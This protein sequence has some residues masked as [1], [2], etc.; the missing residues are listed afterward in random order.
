MFYRD[1]RHNKN[2]EGRSDYQGF[3]QYTDLAKEMFKAINLS[4]HDEDRKKLYQ[5]LLRYYI[6]NSSWNSLAHQGYIG[7]INMFNSLIASEQRFN[8]TQLVKFVES[9]T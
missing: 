3:H 7:H 4:D 5:H 8:E 9:L 2:L 1:V 6:L